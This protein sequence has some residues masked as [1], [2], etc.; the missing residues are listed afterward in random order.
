MSVLRAAVTFPVLVGSAVVV[1]RYFESV[2][3]MLSVPGESG[4]PKLRADRA[5]LLTR[6]ESAVSVVLWMHINKTDIREFSA[7]AVSRRLL[8]SNNPS[9]V[10]TKLVAACGLLGLPNPRTLAKSG[11]RVSLVDNNWAQQPQ[12]SS[13]TSER[14]LALFRFLDRVC[15]ALLDSQLEPAALKLLAEALVEDYFP[16]TEKSGLQPL[17]QVSRAI[18]VISP[19][20]LDRLFANEHLPKCV[21]C[22][23]VPSP[24]S[25]EM[26]ASECFSR[27]RAC[28]SAHSLTQQS[29]TISK[30]AG[31][32]CNRV[33]ASQSST[34][35]RLQWLP[36]SAA[37]VT[38]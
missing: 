15:A 37:V 7:D 2:P 13:P 29:K 10:Q 18:R 6:R 20:V 14:L 31:C 16:T 9:S 17:V 8:Q 3:L 22:V 11:D 23:V 24:L 30:I 12:A 25:L 34:R 35:T 28:L 5:K 38:F 21:Q 36:L 19:S 1:S 32:Q 27:V 26:A 33:V 4:A